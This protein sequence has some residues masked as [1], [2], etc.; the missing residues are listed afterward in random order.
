MI[1][2]ALIIALR[3]Y[4]L[5]DGLI[6][7]IIVILAISTVVAV[8]F[9]ALE[10]FH[11]K[12]EFSKSFGIDTNIAFLLAVITSYSIHYTKLYDPFEQQTDQPR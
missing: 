11:P 2:S 7:L 6:K 1:I 5:I 12:A 9:A 4:S 10:G 8:I 3:K